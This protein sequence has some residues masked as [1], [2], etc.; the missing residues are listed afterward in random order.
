MIN[1]EILA[2]TSRL[3][4]SEATHGQEVAPDHVYVTPPN[5]SLTI[6]EGCC[7]SS[8]H[9]EARGLHL[10]IEHFF[11][12]LADDRQA[13]AIGVVL[14]GTGSDGTTGIE[15]IKVAGGI[16]F[17]QDVA[18]AKY[19]SMRQNADSSGCVDMVLPPA[20]I[21]RA[22][23]RI[24]NHPLVTMDRDVHP[25]GDAADSLLFRRV[26]EI[27]HESAGVDFNAYRAC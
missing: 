10:P 22:V 23:G 13:G 9:G 14:S 16:T 4:V 7:K 20:E 27:L 2:Q 12:S 15:E 11:K 26:L 8:P 6:A 21:A 5:T 3:P 17:A 24:G 25:E 19:P 18:S 1:V